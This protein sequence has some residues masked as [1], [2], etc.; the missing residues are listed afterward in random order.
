MHVCRRYDVEYGAALFKN[1]DIEDVLEII[2]DFCDSYYVNEEE[3]V[4]EVD[5]GEW[6][7]MIDYLKKDK[8]YLSG[9][10]ESMGI[11]EETIIRFLQ[12]YLDD[13]DKNLNIIRIEIF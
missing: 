1:S 13:S 4:V 8:D 11:D 5:K 3:T 6:K 9:Y 7:D 12:V 2:G 10:A